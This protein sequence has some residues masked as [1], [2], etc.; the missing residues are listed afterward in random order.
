MISRYLPDN[1]YKAA[2]S[3][4]APTALNPFATM[5]DLSGLG[6]NMANADLILSDHRTHDGN[7]F[8]YDFS[9]LGEYIQ[10]DY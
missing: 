8:D 1:E 10:L 3:A 9:N 7:G 2:I 6:E 5:A 4:N